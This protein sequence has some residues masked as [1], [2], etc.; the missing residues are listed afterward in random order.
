M[1]FSIIVTIWLLFLFCFVLHTFL[2]AVFIHLA[3]VCSVSQSLDQLLSQQSLV[4]WTLVKSSLG[5]PKIFVRG[6]QNWFVGLDLREGKSVPTREASIHPIVFACHCSRSVMV[7][8]WMF[9]HIRTKRCMASQSSQDLSGWRHYKGRGRMSLSVLQL[10][11]INNNGV[12]TI[13]AYCHKNRS[14]LKQ[15][16][17]ECLVLFCQTLQFSFFSH[18]TVKSVFRLNRHRR[19]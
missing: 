15:H 7:K 13:E 19:G 2:I 11:T 4:S 14:L 5:C 12:L 18:A 6:I 10:W 1:K 17:G 3:K 8:V 16:K 9:C